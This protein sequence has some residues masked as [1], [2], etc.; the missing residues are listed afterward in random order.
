MR[1]YAFGLVVFFAVSCLA[2][3]KKPKYEKFVPPTD[4]H[5]MTISGYGCDRERVATGTNATRNSSYWTLI[6]W[7][8]Y[9]QD[10]K[11]YWQKSYDTFEVPVKPVIG[12]SGESAG[13]GAPIGGYRTEMYDF[14]SMDQA[15]ADWGRVVQSQL[16]MKP[17]GDKIADQ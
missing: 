7:A 10:H 16:K 8:Q 17:N 13:S 14:G 1:R 11:R 15:C 4:A 2:S 6:L 9:G 12:S 3:P 5:G